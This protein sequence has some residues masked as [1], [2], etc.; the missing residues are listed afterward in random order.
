MFSF[1]VDGSLRNVI[2]YITGS[3]ALTFSVTSPT[4]DFSSSLDLGGAGKLLLNCLLY[5]CLHQ[6]YLRVPPSTVVLWRLS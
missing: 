6:V 1:A 5:R 2:V 3:P 4:G